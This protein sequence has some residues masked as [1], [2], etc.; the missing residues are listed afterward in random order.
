MREIICIACPNGCHL[1]V[2]EASLEVTGHTCAIGEEY[3]RTEV[4][5]PTRVITSI[6]R[7]DDGRV[8][9][10]KTSSP[11]PKGKIFD[12]MDLLKP[13]VLKAPVKIGDIIVADICGSGSSWIATKNM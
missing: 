2:D 12:A 7:M 8:C 11:I 3:G 4:T 9:S 6:V 10:V 1:S 5:N 13:I